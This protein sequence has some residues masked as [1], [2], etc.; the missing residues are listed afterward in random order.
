V[1]QEPTA[2]WRTTNLSA[3]APRDIPATPSR[4][5]DH[6]RKRTFATLTLAALELT[7]RQ[8]S[9]AIATT[10]QCAPVPVASSATLWC[11]AGRETV[12]IT[13]SAL[14]HRLVTNTRVRTPATS[15]VAACAAR[16]LTAT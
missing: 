16:T 5:A 12:R 7:A 4:A 10:D 2:R 9:T 11:R 1:V 8:A 15:M 3:P 6:S 13:T 14:T